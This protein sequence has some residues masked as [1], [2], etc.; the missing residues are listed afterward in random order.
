MHPDIDKYAHLNSVIH[1]WDPRVKILSLVILIFTIAMVKQIPSAA[2][3]FAI[4]VT[5]VIISRIPL[6]FVT[7]RLLP[8]SVFLLPFFI[9][10]PL[11]VPGDGGVQ[12]LAFSFNPVG[13][14]L[15]LIIYLKAVSIVI[16]VVTMM[17]TTPFSDSM[18]ALEKLKAPPVLVQMI[19]FSYR[20]LFVFLMEIR[21]MNNAMK[22]RNFEK[23][24]DVHTLKTIGNFVGVLLVRSFERTEK[25]YQA[26]VSRGY[27][28]TL[29]TFFEYKIVMLDYLKGALV[30]L[31]CIMLFIYG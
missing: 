2:I 23:K 30:M 7:K 14:R 20:Y 17:G 24:T 28:G 4:A 31:T 12:V 29:R 3:S 8:V 27:D 21:R 16:L 6:S 22:A 5:L 18:K 11:T 9:I 10:L 19:L 15:A 1:S 26:M 13:L 25:I